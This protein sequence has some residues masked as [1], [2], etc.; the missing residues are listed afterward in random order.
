M[1][2]PIITSEQLRNKDK[3]AL[4]EYRQHIMKLSHSIIMNHQDPNRT[5]YQNLCIAVSTAFMSAMVDTG[6]MTEEDIVLFN[7]VNK[8]PAQ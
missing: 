6:H 1:P 8:E 4:E 2:K 3:A 7:E 5:V